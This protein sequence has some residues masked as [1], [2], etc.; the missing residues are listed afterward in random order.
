MLLIGHQPS[1]HQ[2]IGPIALLL[3][4]I[5]IR[6]PYHQKV[7]DLMRL[8]EQVALIMQHT[9]RIHLRPNRTDNT[10][11]L[12]RKG[13]QAPPVA[14]V[15]IKMETNSKQMLKKIGITMKAPKKVANKYNKLQMKS[16][17]QIS[18]A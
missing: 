2:A 16:F 9:K 12:L 1:Q 13:L 11:G 7:Q 18:T 6:E 10:F 14:K 17:S 8:E 3:N 5:Q 15:K 4:D